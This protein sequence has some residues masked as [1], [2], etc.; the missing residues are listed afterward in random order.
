MAFHHALRNGK[1]SE[2]TA[3][4]KSATEANPTRCVSV[5]NVCTSPGDSFEADLLCVLVVSLLLH[6]AY[7]EHAEGRN[8]LEKCEELFNCLID[9]L[10]AKLD[11]LNAT[12]DEQVT[13]AVESI[14]L[15]GSDQEGQVNGNGNVAMKGEDDEEGAGGGGKELL[16]AKLREREEA[17]Q[18]VL[19]HF[20]PQVND[21]KSAAANVWIVYMRFARRAQ[22]RLAGSVSLFGQGVVED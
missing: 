19:D 21:L 3:L 6:Y 15:E 7:I 20:A 17:K 5:C 16:S 18:A 14:S 22:V 13:A 10:H 4:I 12:V 11:S 8:E 2:A 1:E 9:R